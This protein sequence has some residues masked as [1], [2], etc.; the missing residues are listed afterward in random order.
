MKKHFWLKNRFLILKCKA[1]EAELSPFLSVTLRLL[2][3]CSKLCSPWFLWSNHNS[4]SREAMKQH[5]GRLIFSLLTLL[6][7]C[8]QTATQ[9]SIHQRRPNICDETFNTKWLLE[10]KEK[11]K[12]NHTDI[13][14]IHFQGESRNS[15]SQGF[16]LD[17]VMCLFSGSDPYV[18]EL[19]KEKG[20]TKS[21]GVVRDS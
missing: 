5:R 9:A 19:K 11:E 12:R 4:R 17:T 20:F 15:R 14:K 21:K 18:I 7:L 13:H 1:K 16:Y 3:G 6:F 10:I 2:Q 8:G